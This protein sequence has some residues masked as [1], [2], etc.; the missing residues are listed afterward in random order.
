MLAIAKWK[1]YIILAVCLLGIIYAVPSFVASERL[2]SV[3]S[4]LPREQ[5][6]LGLD[7]Q[8]GSHLLLE[9]NLNAVVE[10]RL[11][12]LLDD[13][14]STLRPE[15]IGYRGLG[16]RGDTVAF[17]L[18][19]PATAQRT[20]ELLD[21]LNTNPIARELEVTDAGNG[22]IEVRL[23]ESAANDLRETAVQ[24]SLEIVRRRI[25]EVGTREPTIQQQ[26]TDRILV[27]IPGLDPAGIAQAREQLQKVAKLEFKL[28][29]P[30]SDQILDAAERGEAIIPP[31]FRVETYKDEGL[32]TRGA[33][34]A[35]KWEEALHS[36]KGL[37]HVI[38]VRNI[39][40]VGAIELQPIDGQPTKRAFSAFL[41]AYEQG[42][43]IR[44]TGDII[45]L[46]PPLIISESQIDE[47]VTRL[48]G[49]L[50]TLD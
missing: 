15:R 14:R 36:L 24:Q 40:L 19:D 48:A 37:P 20:V 10:E 39:G 9:V 38:D 45:A 13:V 23:S 27:Q 25:D 29:H 26:G 47:I 44:T 7:L 32:L 17:T 46:S 21:D 5:V 4:W 34:L 43:L 11:N 1:G 31:D 28:V 49:I 41:Q 22:R 12:S 42:L 2:A 6:T 18:T 35:P 33:E 50:K 16:V 3:P 30:Q 8:G